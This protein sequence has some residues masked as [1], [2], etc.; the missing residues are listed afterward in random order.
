MLW[1]GTDPVANR[2]IDSWK[3][4]AAFFRR[5]ER[6]VKRWEKSKSLPVHRIPGGERGGVFAYTHELTHWLN[7]PLA[8]RD[9]L[10]Q[11][12]LH[13]PLEATTGSQSGMKLLSIPSI[14]PVVER[15]AGLRTWTMPAAA[16]A[17]ASTARGKEEMYSIYK[18]Q[19]NGPMLEYSL[20]KQV[21]LWGW[22]D[23][24]NDGGWLPHLLR[25]HIATVPVTDDS[26]AWH[27]S[28]DE[29]RKSVKSDG[30]T[31]S[32]NALVI[33]FKPNS[34]IDLFLC[35]IVEIWGYS[36]ERWT[37]MMLHIK[38]LV[39]DD[40][41]SVDRHQF[42]IR[43]DDQQALRPIFTVTY[44]PDGTVRAGRVVGKWPPPSPSPTNSALLWPPALEYFA[45]QARKILVTRQARKVG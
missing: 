5:D 34:Q 45:D 12:R 31:P 18:K 44:T 41:L 16:L 25:E 35:E 10:E 19:Q 42:A 37:P 27:I 3:E 15:A 30:D 33:E 38:R 2:R 36:S 26:P 14:Q 21:R 8:A 4:I 39:D 1:S 6:T 11:P 40:W 13:I 20:V 43:N 22:R 9:G 23:A 17:G 32:D 28:C 7:T 24:W 29:I